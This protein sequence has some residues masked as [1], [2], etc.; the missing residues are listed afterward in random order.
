M[1]IYKEKYVEPLKKVNSN[2]LIM[3][4]IFAEEKVP[5]TEA[6]KILKEKM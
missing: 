2:N 5:I 3:K 1:N 4:S 6:G